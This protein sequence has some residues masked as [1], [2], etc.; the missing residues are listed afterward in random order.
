MSDDGLI[1]APAERLPVA[2]SVRVRVRYSECDAQGVAHHSSYVPWL[3][4]AR[5]ELLRGRRV[6]GAVDS[7][8]TPAYEGGLSYAEMERAGVFLVVAKLSVAY[9]L[10][11]VYDEIVEVRAEV[12]GGGRARLDHAYE[13]WRLK[14][15]GTKSALLATAET[16]LACVGRDGRPRPLP[17][18]LRADQMLGA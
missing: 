11:A 5:T 18:W 2:G 15:D 3:E 4:L 13:V 9:K 14:G 16:T 6:L 8:A 7:G 1:G 17:E 10:P 12:T